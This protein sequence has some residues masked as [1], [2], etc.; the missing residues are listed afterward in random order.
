MYSCVA[1]SVVPNE[2]LRLAA[3]GFGQIKLYRSCVEREDN[4]CMEG[5]V[6]TLTS[7]TSDALYSLMQIIL[8][9]QKKM[10]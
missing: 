10:M 1:Y 7:C 5:G 4:T 2:N 3:D 8:D 6:L 9:T